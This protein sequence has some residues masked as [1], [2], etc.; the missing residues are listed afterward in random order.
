M[1]DEIYESLMENN[2]LDRIRL[3]ADPSYAILDTLSLCSGN[4]S[5][6]NLTIA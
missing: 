5:I 1:E 6:E 2:N 3:H 4:R